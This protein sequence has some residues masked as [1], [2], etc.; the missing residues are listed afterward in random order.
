MQSGAVKDIADAVGIL[1]FLETNRS[2]LTLVCNPSFDE[3]LGKLGFEHRR[4]VR[5][6]LDDATLRLGKE[7]KV[8]VLPYGPITRPVPTRN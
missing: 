6:A 2:Q 8:L 1:K 3:D 4:S 5:E 7:S